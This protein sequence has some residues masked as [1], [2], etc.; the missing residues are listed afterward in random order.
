MLK[1]KNLSVKHGQIEAVK[2]VS[3]HINPKE[4]ITLIGSNG[5]GKT[6]L[7]EAIVGLNK[8]IDGEIN[9]NGTDIIKLNSDQIVNLGISLVPEGRQIFSKMTVSDNLLLGAYPRLKKEKVSSIS[10]DFIYTLFPI[11]KEKTKLL[12]GTLSGGQ[13]QMVAIG[14]AL[15][16]K[17]KILLLDEPS[18]G[19]APLVIKDIFKI[20]FNLK[21]Q[22]GISIILVEQNARL[23][24]EYSTRGYVIETGFIVSE[25][26]SKD[27]LS[28]NN[29]VRAY[30][31]KNYKEVTDK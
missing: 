31:G 14:R 8:N 20:L 28:D 10:F 23:A 24:L 9:F 18:T 5:A 12:A 1:I 7:L 16:A 6:S 13:Q 4:I 30:L 22:L 21:E 2:G 17:P 3:L 15:M 26:D 19:L 11:L 25:G 27:L 29:I